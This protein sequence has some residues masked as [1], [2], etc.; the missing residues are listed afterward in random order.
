[1]VGRDPARIHLR[2]NEPA[3]ACVIFVT[4]DEISLLHAKLTFRRLRESNSILGDKAR[5]F[6]RWGPA[7]NYKLRPI[8]SWGRS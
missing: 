4:F 5:L 8:M 1:M 7:D 6:G 2:F 3:T